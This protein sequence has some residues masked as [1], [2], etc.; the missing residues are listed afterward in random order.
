ML[1]SGYLVAHALGIVYRLVFSFSLLPV[2]CRR[3]RAIQNKSYFFSARNIIF[4]QLI[5]LHCSQNLCN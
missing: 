2:L 3:K 4:E 1:R 5:F